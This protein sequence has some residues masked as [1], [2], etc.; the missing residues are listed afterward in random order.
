MTVHVP[1]FAPVSIPGNQA[2]L[3]RDIQCR[4]QKDTKDSVQGTF[5]S[6][7][8]WY[9]SDQGCDLR[10]F[11]SLGSWEWE[12]H[13]VW[14]WRPALTAAKCSARINFFA[15]KHPFSFLVKNYPST[16]VYVVLSMGS[17]QC[18][19]LPSSIM[20]AE[21]CQ[22]LLPPILCHPIKWALGPVHSQL[23]SR[24]LTLNT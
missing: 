24:T 15:I 21:K 11:L 5:L 3:H 23:A 20:E 22:I 12:N 1:F 13:T 19:P 17:L 18:L 2:A 8:T 16:C 4:N 6:T 7:I 10:D 9:I 14:Q